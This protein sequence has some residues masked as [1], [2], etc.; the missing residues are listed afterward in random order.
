GQT[1]LMRMTRIH[2]FCSKFLR[3]KLIKI[4]FMSA[5]VEVDVLGNKLSLHPLEPLFLNM[6]PNFLLSAFIEKTS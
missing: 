3:F 2:F 6:L 1:P 5:E 4:F